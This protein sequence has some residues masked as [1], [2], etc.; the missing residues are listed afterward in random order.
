MMTSAFVDSLTGTIMQDL[1]PEGSQRVRGTISIQSGPRVAEA[2]T[3]IIRQFLQPNYEDADWLLMVDDDMTWAPA[4]F[5]ELLASADPVER[6]I[7]GGLCFAGER[8]VFVR[9]TLYRFINESGDIEPIFDYPRDE[10]IRVDATG[11]AFLLIHRNVLLMLAHRYGK[12]DK[13]V[14]PYPWFVEGMVGATGSSYG[15]DIAFCL[16][17]NHAKIPLHV[18][19][20][21]KI[22]HVKNLVLTEELYDQERKA[23]A[24]EYVPTVGD[25]DVEVLV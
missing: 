18:N 15:E 9:P 10:V 8:G 21:V 24:D 25:R 7:V 17:L 22:G 3:Q 5:D 11:A 23:K 1:G 14:S 6:P 2:R 13:G 19:T 4:A 12:T 20:A 16:R